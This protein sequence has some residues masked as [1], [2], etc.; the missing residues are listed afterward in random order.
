MLHMPKKVDKNMTILRRELQDVKVTQWNIQRWKIQELIVEEINKLDTT[1]EKSVNLSIQQEK[2]SK[3]S[4]KRLGKNRTRYQWPVG[5][6]QLVCMCTRSARRSKEK[7]Y[8]W[9]INGWNVSKFQENQKST[10][11]R[12]STNLKEDKHEKKD[13]KAYHNKVQIQC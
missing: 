1:K 3:R 6:H 8:F 12:C 5:Q 4:R 10:N 2:L 11:R 13:V 7:I 9:K